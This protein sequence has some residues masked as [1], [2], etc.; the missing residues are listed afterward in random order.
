MLAD[1][2]EIRFKIKIAFNSLVKIA[3]MAPDK[4]PRKDDA[5]KFK[6][7]KNKIKSKI[8]KKKKSKSVSSVPIDNR[9][10][11]SEW[12]DIFWRKNSPTLGMFPFL[13]VHFQQVKSFYC[14]FLDLYLLFVFTPFL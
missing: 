9:A 13:L 2:N 10:V 8:K 1:I 4:K 12:W 11:D 6:K 7:M 3:G 14:T 5:K